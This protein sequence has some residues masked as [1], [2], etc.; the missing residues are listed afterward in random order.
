MKDPGPYL[1]DIGVKLPCA[2]IGG[3]PAKMDARLSA[4]VNHE[5]YFLKFNFF[6]IVFVMNIANDNFQYI[7]HRNQA[8]RPAIFVDNNRQMGLLGLKVS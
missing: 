6:L 7:F 3:M 2:T 4:R 1:K 5:I 8:R